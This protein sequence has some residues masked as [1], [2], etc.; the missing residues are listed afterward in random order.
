MRLLL[1]NPNTSPDITALIASEAAR[2]AGP[3]TEITLASGRFGPRYIESRASAAIATHA[4]IE[5]FAEHYDGHDAVL[6]ACFG[7]P[8]LLAV[9]EL[10]PVPVLGLAESSCHLACLYAGRF[11]VVTGGERWGPMLSEFVGSLGLSSRLASIRTVAPSGA[12]IA[13]DPDGAI[14]LLRDAA[15]ACVEQ[16]GAEL[17]ILGG[18]GLAGLTERFAPGVAVPVLCSLAAGLA[19]TAAAVRLGLA[20]AKRGSFATTPPVETIGLSPAL[21]LMMRGDGGQGG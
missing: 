15:T 16:D 3:E 11:S 21:M 7:E 1:I 2:L 8:G 6:L 4:A 5:A 14:S 19:A 20:K 18:A 12:D 9:R 17:V 10:A 13:R